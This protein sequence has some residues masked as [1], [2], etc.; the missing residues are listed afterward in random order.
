MVRRRAAAVAAAVLLS[1]AVGAAAQGSVET[2]RAALEA[3]YHATDGPNWLN[4]ENWLSAEPLEEWV[5]VGT[6]VTGRVD[7][8]SLGGNQLSGPIPAELGRL[9]NLTTLNLDE[10]QLSGPIPAELGRLA[11]LTTLNLGENQLSGPIPAELGRLAN[12]TTLNLDEN[13][14]SGPIPAELGRL[15]N[16]VYLVLWENQLSGPI[17]AEL[18]RLANLT[19]LNLDENQLSGPIPAELGRLANLE[20]LSLGGNQLSGPIPAELGRLANLVYL[21]LWENQ[22]SGR[23]P[24]ELGRLAN[25]Q[26]LVLDGDTGLC[27]PAD[28]PESEFL[29]QA[30]L[31]GVPA[32]ADDEPPEPP[33][34]PVTPQSSCQL[35][36]SG[37]SAFTG[38]GVA[39]DTCEECS[40]P[41]KKSGE[42][43]GGFWDSTRHNVVVALAKTLNWDAIDAIFG[44]G[45]CLGEELQAESRWWRGALPDDTTIEV[46]SSDHS[47]L[48]I[49]DG[50]ETITMVKR[51]AGPV[52]LQLIARGG[53]RAVGVTYHLDLSPAVVPA[54]PVFGVVALG[55]ALAAAGMVRIRRR[56][57]SC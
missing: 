7:F 24:A 21:V 4:N 1:A 17:P 52:A 43:I 5:R 14:L 12:L 46:K 29:R 42:V 53:G 40:E 3:L 55:A 19:T 45:D 56:R 34:C 23:I 30:R 25:L 48:E 33:W 57:R 31:L 2:D 41:C 35:S 39:A 47:V 13:Q 9:A 28:F 18:G 26:F 51:G 10:N 54:L 36:R 22:L 20:N 44:T 6:D 16:L 11:N 32:C 49:I 15:A 27:L 50:P 38:R 8:L 37:A